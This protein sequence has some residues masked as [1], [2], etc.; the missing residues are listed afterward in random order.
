MQDGV[1]ADYLVT[2]AML[3]YF[4][5]RSCGRF[6]LFRPEIMIAVPTGVTTVEQRAV[7][8]AAMAAGA[9]RVILMSE[10]ALQ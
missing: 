2:E 1:I 6:R 5:E 9:K 4:L 8:D 7:I 10:R 3:R